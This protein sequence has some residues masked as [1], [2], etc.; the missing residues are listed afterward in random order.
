MRQR[1]SSHTTLIELTAALLCFL[2]A[3][4]IILGLFTKADAI[5]RRSARLQEATTLA[6]DCAEL[7]A[8]SGNVLE[9]L[10]QAGYRA[11]N[12]SFTLKTDDGLVIRTELGEKQ[13]EVGT[14]LDGRICVLD[15][16]EEVFSVPAARY[17]N[18][19]VIHP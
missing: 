16:E 5:S 2:L 10:T 11:E 13:T 4:V 8:G 1:F 7:I 9:A 12:G 17:Y 18:K 19:E 15:G 6:Q 3:S 14:L